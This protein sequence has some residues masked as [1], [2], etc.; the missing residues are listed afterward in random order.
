MTR[1]QPPAKKKRMNG[2]QKREALWGYLFIAPGTILLLIFVVFPVLAAGGISLTKWT[3]LSPPI[4]VGLANYQKLISDQIFHKVLLNTFYYSAV[5]IPLGIVCSLGMAVVLNQKI[6]GLAIFRTAYYLPVISASVAVSVVWMWLLDG[7]YGLINF[8][9]L[10]LGLPTVAWLRNTLWAMPAIILV[11]VWKNMGFNM[12]IYL[13]ALQDVPQELYES[14]RI[15]GAGRW[16]LFNHITLPMI[17]P[18]LFFTIITGIISSF[19]SFDLVYNMTDG[20]PARSTTVI[21]YYIWQQAFDFLQMGYGA[22]IA[23]VLFFLI[24]GITLVQWQARKR[25]VF[26]EAEAP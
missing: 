21:G 14:A 26:G 20:G 8:F 7:N 4:F 1:S 25:W 17:S 12:I 10:R 9:L 23:Y 22:T 6:R 24:M 16:K 13:A 18:A 3:L 5:S 2:M 15:D 19:Q 11:T